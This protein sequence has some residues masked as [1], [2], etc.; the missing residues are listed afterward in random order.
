[1]ITQMGSTS[2]DSYVE[3]ITTDLSKVDPSAL[4]D[5]IV[6]SPPRTGTTWLASV[7]SQHPEIYI[8]PEKELN[9]FSA[10]WKYSNIEFYISRFFPANG[11]IKGDASPSYVLLPS[12][13]ISQL[14]RVKP[15]LKFIVIER[16][17]AERAWSHLNHSYA[18]N[19]FDLRSGNVT[20]AAIDE[21]NALSYL[22]SDYS[23]VVGNYISYLSRWLVHFPVEQFFVFGIDEIEKC[24][25]GLI[26]KLLTFLGCKSGIENINIQGKVNSGLCTGILTEKVKNVLATL[27]GCR[28]MQQYRFFSENFN[29]NNFDNQSCNNT[30]SIIF[31]LIDR[32]DGFRI[33]ICNGMFYA[34]VIEDYARIIDKILTENYTDADV[35]SSLYYSDLMRQI[36]IQKTGKPARSLGNASM[37]S[38]ILFSILEELSAEYT[39]SNALRTNLNAGTILREQFDYNIVAIGGMIVAV[40]KSLGPI[41]LGGEALDVLAQRYGADKF[42]IGHSLPEVLAILNRKHG[43]G[44][45]EKLEANYL[46]CN[47]V[48]YNGRIYGVPMSAGPL[49]VDKQEEAVLMSFPSA[50]SLDE[51]KALLILGASQLEER[52][53]SPAQL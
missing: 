51:L 43:N 47:L 28:Q 33:F 27:Y 42:I 16:N 19:E 26:Q 23:V 53:Q 29:Y 3:R 21:T 40:Q 50:E 14:Y 31:R 6:L 44:K 35:L 37:E 22:T 10:G 2:L 45:P 4:P 52:K 7:L 11:R 15:N 5:F 30:C 12:E 39:K 25:S 36:D 38:A 20:P 17:M 41:N 18:F 13:I 9:Y 8:P 46:G 49:E 24:G 34:C 1:M 32:A 48:L